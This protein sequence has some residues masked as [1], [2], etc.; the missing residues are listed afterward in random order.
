ML[1]AFKRVLQQVGFDVS[2]N[3]YDRLEIPKPNRR[4]I[5]RRLDRSW[6]EL[7]SL[8]FD[9]GTSNT[10]HDAL[11][12]QNNTLLNR[13]EKERDLTQIF[14][15][16]CLA[17]IAKLKIQPIEIPKKENSKEKLDLHALRSD[18]HVGE[19]LDKDW[20]QGL[21]HYDSN[22]Y[23]KR[24]NRWVEKLI[25]FR[26]QDKNSLSLNKLIINHL[27][28]Q[29]TGEAI[30]KGQSFYLDLSLTDQLFY[31]VEV[32]SNAV[33]TLAKYF[34]EVEIFAVVG[35]HGRPGKKG[36]NHRRTNF[37]YIFYR[38]LKQTLE[39]Q[40]NVKVYVSES[41]SMVVQHGDFTFLLTHGDAARGWMG[42]PFYGLERM[43]RRLPNLYNM[44][45]HYQLCGHHHQPANIGDSK[46]LLNGSL[47][48]GSELSINRIGL[49]NLPAQKI[50]YFDKKHGINR[51]TNIHLADPVILDPDENG[52]Y[53]A[54]T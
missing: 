41:P 44:M 16:N 14:V 32:E 50:F 36:A 52:I 18:A 33:L 42:I 24:V 13:L 25:T 34:P 39:N 30:F 37:D 28:D 54:H 8:V 51:E 47:V 10:T 21:S 12:N 49:S 11:I 7:K 4:T 19:Y 6:A 35:N 27:G 53:T 38:S 46:I 3:T 9:D 40:K 43:F 2:A 5:E 22:T 17:A 29:V 31:S 23:E 15:N 20:V 26:E 45:I 48:G 1:E